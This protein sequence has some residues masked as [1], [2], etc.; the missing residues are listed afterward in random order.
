L[1]V[2]RPAE[3]EGRGSLA[4][5]GVGL[6]LL[7]LLGFAGVVLAFLGVQRVD[8][9]TVFTVGC[10]SILMLIA[11]SIMTAVGRRSQTP[12]SALATDLLGGCAS[13]LLGVVLGGLLVLA[14]IAYAINDCMKGCSPQTQQQRR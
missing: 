7:G 1:P 4:A 8:L 2:V 3:R 5:I 6:I 14:T 11:G 10:G 12:T 13:G 9:D